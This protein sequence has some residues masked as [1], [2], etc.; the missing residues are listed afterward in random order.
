MRGTR[1]P[2]SN[3]GTGTPS[4]AI[5]GRVRW[6]SCVGIDGQSVTVVRLASAASNRCTVPRSV[7]R[8]LSSSL[9]AN[10]GSTL[11]TIR[12]TL[13]LF[14]T[15]LNGELIREQDLSTGLEGLQP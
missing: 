5:A 6:A 8:T 14:L 11:A 13:E 4:D 12:P 7:S 1:E 9:P 3:R 2:R 15:Q 10:G